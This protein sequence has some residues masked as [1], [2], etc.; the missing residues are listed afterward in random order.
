MIPTRKQFFCNII[1]D[2]VFKNGPSKMCW[3]QPWIWMSHLIFS[4]DS[5]SFSWKQ[6]I[7]LILPYYHYNRLFPFTN[8]D[9]I[10]KKTVNMWFR[11][12]F[13]LLDHFARTKVWSLIF[14][15]FAL[16]AIQKKNTILHNLKTSHFLR[17]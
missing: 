5:F 16:S 8:Y 12:C 2:K 3:R 4:G 11:Q 7:T 13:L 15:I 6:I 17:K 14:V 9:D 1:W 10:C